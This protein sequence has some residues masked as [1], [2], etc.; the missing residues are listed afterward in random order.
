MATENKPE[1]SAKKAI[2]L[3]PDGAAMINFPAI[4]ETAY[5]SSNE[6]LSAIS[7]AMKELFVD[8]EGCKIDSTN[9]TGEVTL[10]FGF[11]HGKYND[12]GG[13][14]YGVQLP[15]AQR[16]EN[17]RINA[18]R[19]NDHFM[20]AGDRYY[21]TEELAEFL[22]PYLTRPA[23]NNGKPNWKNL[24]SE[25]R[26]GN[27]YNQGYHVP[28]RTEVRGISLRA[29]CKTLFG[30]HGE[31]G[32]DNYDYDVMIKDYPRPNPFGQVSNEYILA[33]I[34]CSEDEVKK[35]YAHYGFVVAD[36]NDLVR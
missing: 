4:A 26:F 23:F 21:V 22:K 10:V 25:T 29:F 9:T 1:D 24:C 32:S 7:R 16:T 36:N 15:Q 5:I 18:I 30:I 14:F 2:E 33:V 12:L 31:D 6:L 8:F 3:N 34:R 11:N 35:M 13:K 28:Q 27:G 19:N 20:T 17:E